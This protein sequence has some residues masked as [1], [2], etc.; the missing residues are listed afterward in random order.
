MVPLV[1]SAIEIIQGKAKKK[2]VN[3]STRAC[4]W[5]EEH[6]SM[7]TGVLNVASLVTG[8]IFAGGSLEM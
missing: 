1:S 5:Q 2:Y 6:A 7:I 8:S 4:V 3:T